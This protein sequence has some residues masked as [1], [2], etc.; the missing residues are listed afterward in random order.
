[1]T[2]VNVNHRCL[3]QA[4]CYSDVIGEFGVVLP[5][6]QEYLPVFRANLEQWMEVTAGGHDAHRIKIHLLERLLFP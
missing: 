1:M 3:S 5:H 4:Y 2:R 6:L